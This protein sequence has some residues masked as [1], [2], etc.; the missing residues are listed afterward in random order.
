M[1]NAKSYKHMV[2]LAYGKFLI[3]FTKAFSQFYVNNKIYFFLFMSK[4]S[5]FTMVFSLID[6]SFYESFLSILLF[7]PGLFSSFMI[8]FRNLLCLYCILFLALFL[9]LSYLYIKQSIVNSIFY[10]RT[11]C[12]IFF[13]CLLNSSKKIF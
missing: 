7:I 1:L 4:F 3:D 2:N 5:P 6:Y 13:C 12:V 9:L 10:Y 11:G 8:L